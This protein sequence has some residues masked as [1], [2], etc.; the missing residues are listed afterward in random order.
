LFGDE[1]EST[2]A[3]KSPQKQ[4]FNFDGKQERHK[5][6]SGV[7]DGVRLPP[8]GHFGSNSSSLTEYIVQLRSITIDDIQLN[9]LLS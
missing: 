2:L 8:R 7:G 6:Y 5:I 3:C 1:M 9:R 4:G